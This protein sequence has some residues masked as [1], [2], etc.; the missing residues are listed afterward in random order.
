VYFG[1]RCVTAITEADQLTALVDEVVRL[2]G[3]FLAEGDAIVAP[4]DLTAA[5]WLVLGAL[6]D[7][8]MSIAELARRRGLSRQSVRESVIRLERDGMVVRVPNSDDARSP[9]LALT[10]AAVKALNDIE[11]MRAAWATKVAAP[12]TVRELSTALSVLRKVQTQ[13]A[14]LQAVGG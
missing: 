2:S 5:R 10:S 11:P 9:L 3:T 7:E 13:L 1:D 6:A 8:S 12:L 4:F 14:Q